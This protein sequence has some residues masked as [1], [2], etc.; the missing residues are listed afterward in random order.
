[1]NQDTDLAAVMPLRGRLDLSLEA[2]LRRIVD[3]NAEPLGAIWSRH[4]VVRYVARGSRFPWI[5]LDRNDRL[6]EA[7]QSH[8]A[9]RRG[10]RRITPM[11][12]AN[13]LPG[14]VS[15][16]ARCTSSLRS[17]PMAMPSP[18]YGCATNQMTVA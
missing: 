7:T 12:E 17:A 11:V 16:E 4:G 8:R 5:R 9:A 1:M 15:G 2:A 10:E 3:L 6:P 13:P 14:S 18:F